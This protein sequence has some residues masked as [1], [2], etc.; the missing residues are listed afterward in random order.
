LAVK[1]LYNN[2]NKN[3]K[4]ETN[5]IISRTGASFMNTQVPSSNGNNEIL[6]QELELYIKFVVGAVV[7]VLVVVCV[8]VIKFVVA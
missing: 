2:N 1:F 8:I 7:V 3:K 5:I 6:L 4:N